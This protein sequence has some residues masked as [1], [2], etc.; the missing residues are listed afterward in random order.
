MRNLIVL[1]IVALLSSFSFGQ[2]SF[3]NYY[4]DNGADFGEGIVQLEDSSYVITGASSSFGNAPSQA[5]LM[6]IDSMGNYMWSKSYGGPESESGRR[7]L[8]K[9]NFGF[10]ICGYTNSYGAGGFDFY[11][12]KVDE[13]ANLEW[14]NT[15]GGSGWDRINDAA[16]TRDTGTLLVGETSSNDTDNMDIYI[17]RTDKL[18]DT[19]WTKTI[20]GIGDDKASCILK[21]TDSTYFIGG[22]YYLED[23]VQTKG[24]M[25]FLKDDGTVF[26]EK[27]FGPNGDYWVTDL[28]FDADPTKVIGTGGSNGPQTNET[29]AYLFVMQNTGTFWG[30]FH[31]SQPG[32]MY[33]SEMANYGS[34]GD[35]YVSMVTDNDSGYDFGD[36]L[37][38]NRYNSSLSFQSSFGMSHD[39]PDYAGDIIAT[40]DGGAIVVGYSTGVISGGNE[41][42]VAKIGPNE[43]Y[44]DNINNFTINNL[45]LLDELDLSSQVSLFPNPSHGDVTIVSQTELYDQYNVISSSGTLIETGSFNKELN[46]SMQQEGTGLYFIELTGATVV[47]VRLKL[48]VQ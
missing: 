42:T 11:L 13:S 21:Y 28:A 9:K 40:S 44:P 18:G 33:H 2:I 37:T 17:V 3:F 4:S 29:D 30:G 5:F 36:D 47:P 25:M 45:V 10:F 12:A 1:F 32:Q 14:E 7:V 6:Q 39:Y 8:Y 35:F 22:E 16:L 43:L 24:Y 15:Y 34:N 26:W 31:P 38:I 46:L 20:G 23:S 27:T 19:L 48:V 41:I